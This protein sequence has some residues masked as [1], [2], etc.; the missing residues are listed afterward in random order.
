MI[1]V[2]VDQ[3]WRQQGELTFDS[4]TEGYTQKYV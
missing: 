1:H 4:D 2:M 3:S